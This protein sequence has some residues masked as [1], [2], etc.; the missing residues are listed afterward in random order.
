[1]DLM[2]EKQENLRRMLRDMETVAV[3]FSSGVDST[4]L[5]T[6]AH[7][8]LGNG[9]IAI[10]ASSSIFP[11]RENE[12][13]RNFC[14]EEGIAQVVLDTD[15]LDVEGFCENPKDRCYRCKRNLFAKIKKIAQDRGLA[16]VAEGSNLDDEGD[17]RPGMR[18]IAELGIRSPL[19][20]VGLTKREIRVLSKELGLPTW[21]KPSYACLASRFPYGETITVEKLSMVDRA[22]DLLL[23][24]GFRQMRVRFHGDVAR[25][26][27]EREQ[28]ARIVSPEIA[29]QIRDYLH[30]LGFL[31]VAVDLDGYK[32]GSL[33][34]KV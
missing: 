28:L 12:E 20:E 22:E 31:Y 30:E 27:V 7:D 18:A 1:M 11:K 23:R 9:A 4:Y 34:K 25:I 26:E 15:P 13:T 5:L 16:F 2:H 32:T 19:R 17:Y 24:L 33:N 21:D 6:T 29:G 14:A 8:V 3:A 10:T